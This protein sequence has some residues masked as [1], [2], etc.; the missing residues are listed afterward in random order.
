MD[1]KTFIAFKR[2]QPALAQALVEV[3]GGEVSTRDIEK[4]IDA[5]RSQIEK[6]TLEKDPKLAFMQKTIKFTKGGKYYRV[7]I[8][9][10]AGGNGSAYCF[11]D[12]EGN[13][14]KAASWKTPAKGI[15]GHIST[16]DVRKADQY[17]SWLYRR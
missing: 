12:M 13:I 9:D 11:I 4:W 14:Y 10:K 3:M 17:T 6:I 2:R 16:T 15:R 1:R 7:V 5:L 8:E